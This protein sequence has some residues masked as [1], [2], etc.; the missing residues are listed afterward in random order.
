M[1]PFLNDSLEVIIGCIMKMFI[2]NKVLKEAVT[3]CQLV[4]IK[5]SNTRNQLVLDDV[6]LTTGTGVLLKS[7]NVNKDV[8]NIFEKV[9]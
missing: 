8:K 1:M 9:M 7:H 5:I 6:K 4:K 2:L 3:S